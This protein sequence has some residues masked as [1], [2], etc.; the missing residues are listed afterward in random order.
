MLLFGNLRMNFA[1]SKKEGEETETFSRSR[2]GNNMV[3]EVRIHLDR[4]F[5]RK[6]QI[7]RENVAR[8][9]LT[10]NYAEALGILSRPYLRDVAAVFNIQ[11]P[12]QVSRAVR[13]TDIDRVRTEKMGLRD[14][15]K[16]RTGRE[17]ANQGASL[18]T[19]LDRGA[20]ACGNSINWDQG[21]EP[22]L[23]VSQLVPHLS[24]NNLAALHSS[25]DPEGSERVALFLALEPREQLGLYRNLPDG[26]STGK[27]MQEQLLAGVPRERVF[28]QAFLNGL[29]PEEL[30]AFALLMKKVDMNYYERLVLPAIVGGTLG[31]KASEVVEETTS[32]LTA[33]NLGDWVPLDLREI[34][35][36]HQ[37]VLGGIVLARKKT[38]AIP[39]WDYPWNWVLNCAG[40]D[41]LYISCRLNRGIINAVVDKNTAAIQGRQAKAI[42]TIYLRDALILST[43]DLQKAGN[44]G[45]KSLEALKQM[46]RQ[47]IEGIEQGNP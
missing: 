16:A 25:L 26:M 17:I 15:Q 4:F 24:F 13:Q 30:I 43:G 33:E 20:A 31:P 22:A 19:L 10:T 47:I 29:T 36:S 6:V 32:S 44:F 7:R 11:T 3:G 8:A 42:E 45:R 12:P 37:N 46:L 38:N 27:F 23:V 41:T 14:I 9:R 18:K 40:S 39:G 35:L 5:G 28:N 21:F 2:G 1:V 34:V